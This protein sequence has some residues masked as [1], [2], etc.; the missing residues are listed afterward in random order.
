[1]VDQ[2]KL[3]YGT[4]T[5]TY[6]IYIGRRIQNMNKKEYARVDDKTKKNG[7]SCKPE[8]HSPSYAITQH[9][10]SFLL[11]AFLNLLGLAGGAATISSG[12]ARGRLGFNIF[13]VPYVLHS[14]LSSPS[15]SSLTVEG[16]NLCCSPV[17]CVCRVH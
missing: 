9:G 7:D 8:T 13:P 3:P 15:C 16:R 14:C 6:Y 5:G 1:M 4:Q 2:S 17:P 12:S 11:S 10:L